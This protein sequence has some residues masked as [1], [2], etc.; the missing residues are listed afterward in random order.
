[1]ICRLLGPHDNVCMKRS[2]GL[3]PI[4]D[5]VVFDIVFGAAMDATTKGKDA[6][7]Q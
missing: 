1:M 7:S 2:V 6:V 3:Y 5:D 4:P